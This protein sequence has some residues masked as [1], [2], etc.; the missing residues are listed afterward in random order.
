M[1]IPLL[2][3]G[4]VAAQQPTP[5]MEYGDPIANS[6]HTVQNFYKLQIN[7]HGDWLAQAFW[8]PGI[9]QFC[10]IRNGA[11]EAEFRA[12]LGDGPGLAP[13]WSFTNGIG[14]NDAGETFYSLF[15]SN[16]PNGLLDDEGLYYD[17]SNLVALESDLVLDPSVPAGSVWHDWDNLVLNNTGTVL[18]NADYEDGLT[19]LDHRVF[20]KLG[21]DA[22]GEPTGVEEILVGEGSIVDGDPVISIAVSSRQFDMNDNGDVIAILRLGP[23][24]PQESVIW[25][26]GQAVARDREI[27]TVSGLEWSSINLSQV[28][29]NNRGDYAFT[30][31]LNSTVIRE[32]VFV[33]G[34]PLVLYGD[35]LPDIAPF[36]IRR[37]QGRPIDIADTGDVLW[38]GEFN[39][40]N[41]GS[42][43]ALFLNDSL[44]VRTGVTQ[45]GGATV[46]EL[47]TGEYGY[48][49]SDNGRY[50]VFEATLSDGRVGLYQIDLVPGPVL[51]PIQ[52][53]V[54]GQPNTATVVNLNPGQ[55]V[56]L[57][58][59]RLQGSQTIN[60]SG[61]TVEIGLANPAFKIASITADLNGEAS[62]T[63][64]V[65]ANQAGITWYM[66]ALDLT[67]CLVS[68]V[69]SVTF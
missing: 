61:G 8:D 62:Y 6:S 18:V 64:A 58:A 19:G 7:N 31:S 39:D 23:G 42:N 51:Q 29:M 69:V 47:D 33:N 68:N 32:G 55:K 65:S 1:F 9:N 37:V 36:E 21:I 49:L 27:S 30:A 24:G 20:A 57:G 38:W 67:N 66:Q 17:F 16:N 40:T 11:L 63:G 5:L 15:F 34:Q 45:I 10:L 25:V 52:P 35:Q 3:F 60:C 43:D 46:E 54:A 41:P 56:L 22:Q 44:L 48:F 14:F 13:H 4:C 12:N 26:N 2:L 53:G 59:S 28:A 50:V